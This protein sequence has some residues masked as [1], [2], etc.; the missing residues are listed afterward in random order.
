MARLVESF[1]T[2]E[3]SCKPIEGYYREL[4]EAHDYLVRNATAA[5]HGTAALRPDQRW[6]IRAKRVRVLLPDEHRPALI[7]PELADHNLAEVINQCATVERLL[8]VLQWASDEPSLQ[9]CA[10]ERCHPTT[11]SA[12]NGRQDNDLVL[13]KEGPYK[14][15]AR[16][17]VSDV[18]GSTDGNNKQKRDL[19]SLGILRKKTFE[20]IE[21]WPNERLFL[22]VSEEF[23]GRILGRQSSIPGLYYE[24]AGRIQDTFVV[25]VKKGAVP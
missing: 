14:P 24:S 11:G 20:P 6:G 15:V 21:E 22:V 10:V 4:R 1:V 13:V 7:G 23:N 5:L 25:E 3:G 17:E 8:D 16:F 12:K 2:R 19:A 18:I 9:G